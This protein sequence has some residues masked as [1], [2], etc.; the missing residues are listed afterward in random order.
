MSQV[1]ILIPAYKPSDRFIATMQSLAAQTYRDCLVHVSVDDCEASRQIPLPDMGRMRVVV[2]RQPRR[3]GWVGNVNTLVAMVSSPYFMVLA[4]DDC[5]T[6]RYVERAV[7]VL[8][9]SPDVIT[10]HGGI[11]WHG[12]RDGEVGLGCD[13]QGEPIDRIRQCMATG[14]HLTLGWRGVT[15]AVAIDRGLRLRSRRSN[16]LFAN[17]LWELELLLLGGS[18]AISDIYYDKY[19]DPTGLSRTYHTLSYD[20]KTTALADNVAALV[21]MVGFHGLDVREQEEIVSSYIKWLLDL[22][23]AWS[24]FG[25]VLN[26]RDASQGSDRSALERF[27]A[28]IA[29]L[30]NSPPQPAEVVDPPDVHDRASGD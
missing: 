29:I 8:D 13:I 24:I 15:K 16:G 18:V 9:R 14:P 1:T 11:R 23:G 25:K 21:E 7:D 30:V 27:A 17:H 12:I 3:L 28:Q 20:Q 19:T 26:A 22:G 10:A 5:I 2:T 6:P 4:H